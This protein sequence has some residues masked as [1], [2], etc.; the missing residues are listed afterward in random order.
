MARLGVVMPNEPN[1]TDNGNL[2]TP[3]DLARIIKTTPQTVLNLF[4]DGIIPARVAVGRVIRFDRAEALAAL[5]KH[6]KKGKRA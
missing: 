6:S 2:D 5:A 1:D 3:R 4:H